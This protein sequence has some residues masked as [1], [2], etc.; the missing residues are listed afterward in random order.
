[1]GYLLL[2]LDHLLFWLV[3][4]RDLPESIQ[5]QTLLKTAQYKRAYWQYKLE[6][7]N[8]TSMIFHHF[9]FHIVLQLISLFMF[10]SNS[11]IIGRAILLA[12]NIHLFLHL[13]TDFLKRPEHLQTWFFARMT[14]QLP[15]SFL[16]IYLKMNLVLILIFA[17][18]FFT[19][20]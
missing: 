12:A 16:S 13:Y 17:I 10:T 8:H 9:Y 4:H 3:T 6:K 5:M 14:K 18:L 2:D 19:R 11:S 20:I 15:L 7:G 1:M